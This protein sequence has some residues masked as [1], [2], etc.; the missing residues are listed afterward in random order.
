VDCFL[1]GFPCQPHSTA[2]KRAGT[3]DA[4]WIWP[5]IARIVR[6]SGAW[7]VV[8]ENVPG[9][10]TSGGYGPVLGDLAEMG[11]AAEWGCLSAASVGASHER[12]R[13]FIVGVADALRVSG[14]Q[15]AGRERVL[16]GGAQDRC[17]VDDAERRRRDRLAVY[18]G[19]GRE[20][21]GARH[22]CGTGDQD[23]RLAVANGAH[24]QGGGTAVTRQDGKSR[25][26]MLDWR[27]EA[28]SLP[29][30]TTP[31]G[32]PSSP[33]APTSRLRLN[34]AFVCWLMGLPPAWTNIAHTSC[35]L[36]E[37][38]SYRSKLQQQLRSCLNASV[39][40]EAA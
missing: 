34:P 30:P 19:P 7:L 6:D 29:A 33:S 21:L 14:G 12:E 9:L 38:E 27:A 20:G 17:G 11:F 28:F 36:A 3:D 13:V 25:M 4:R 40:R 8:L 22:A 26:D 1:A 16:D 24:P 32:P 5:D 37:M 18:A 31:D 35:G 39:S 10:L 2:G 15:W 23:G